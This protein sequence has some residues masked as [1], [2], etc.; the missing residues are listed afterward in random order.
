[1]ADYA[2]TIAEVGAFTMC[3]LLTRNAV[4]RARELYADARSLTW[5]TDTSESSSM[6]RKLLPVPFPPPVARPPIESGN[7][8]SR[9]PMRCSASVRGKPFGIRVSAGIICMFLMF[10]ILSAQP[11]SRA[12]VCDGDTSAPAGCGAVGNRRIAFSFRCSH[13]WEK[14]RPSAAGFRRGY[15]GRPGG[16]VVMPAIAFTTVAAGLGGADPELLKARCDR[17]RGRYRQFRSDFPDDHAVAY[18]DHRRNVV[19]D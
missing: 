3:A 1:M 14:A 17:T 19:M 6:F 18:L 11:K 15:G 13:A 9:I 10:V 8:C 7:V 2:I 16:S 12:V 4:L 5:H